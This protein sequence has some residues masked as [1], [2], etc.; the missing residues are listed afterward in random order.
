MPLFGNALAGAAGSGGDAGYTIK[1]SLRFNPD[2][3]SYLNKNFASAGRRKTW[4][5]AAWV[6]RGGL[7]TTQQLFVGGPSDADRLNIRFESDDRLGVDE[8]SSGATQF[9]IK[10]AR[11]F[12]DPAAWMHLTVAFNSGDVQADRLKIYCNGKRVT[13][14]NVTTAV[15]ASYQG[16]INS[17]ATHFIGKHAPSSGQY[18]NGLMGEVHFIDGLALAPDGVF[19]EFDAATGVWVP[20]EYTGEY[21]FAVN[22]AQTWS[23]FGGSGTYSANYNWTKLFDSDPDSKT[24][25]ANGSSITADFTSLSGGGIAYTSSLEVHYRRNTNAPDV[26]VNGSGISAPNN[27]ADNIYKVSG[28][29]TLT[30]VGTQQR[31]TAGAGDC[32]LF[33]IVIDGKELVDAGVTPNN[34]GFHLDFDPTAGTTYSN[35]VSSTSTAN[36]SY[37]ASNGFDGSVGSSGTANWY[38]Q[39]SNQTITVDLSSHNITASSSVG[40]NVRLGGPGN[41]ATVSVTATIGGTAYTQTF[42]NSSTQ[43]QLLTFSGSGAVTTIVATL[44]QASSSYGWGFTGVQVDGA[45]LVDHEAPGVDASGTGNHWTANNLALAAVSYTN[46]VTSHGGNPQNMWDGNSASFTGYNQSNEIRVQFTTPISGSNLRLRVNTGGGSPIRV[47]TDGGSNWTGYNLYNGAQETGD[48]T[49][50]GGSLS[51]LRFKQIVV[52]VATSIM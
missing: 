23:S 16:R 1:R 20:I 52:A 6:K 36:S 14:L 51:D 11:Q 45:Y 33:R 9:Y 13:D 26:T 8:Y 5:W 31:T 39:G 7:G 38:T 29:G 2:D 44:T 35:N 30:S 12:R 28:S 49:I 40:F 3:T 47:S 50:T 43:D 42:Q 21:R 37:P 25:P 27:G 10:T 19:G 46:M 4:T 18:Y 15:P 17:Q 48:Y 41:S 24:V 22:Q 32:S 34:N